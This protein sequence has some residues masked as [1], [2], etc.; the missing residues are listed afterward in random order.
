MWLA[1]MLFLDNLSELVLQMVVFQRGCHQSFPDHLAS[2]EVRSI[3]LAGKVSDE[4]LRVLWDVMGIDER[5]IQF[6]WLKLTTFL[7]QHLWDHL[8]FLL[9]SSELLLE[10]VQLLSELTCLLQRRWQLSMSDLGALCVYAIYLLS[11]GVDLS[12]EDLFTAFGIDAER[13]FTL[14]FMLTSIYGTYGA[15]VCCSDAPFVMLEAR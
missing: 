6:W 3:Q 13:P 5:L 15:S 2:F 11:D 4:V 1:L 8:L 9:V 7:L 10:V 14:S 12:Q